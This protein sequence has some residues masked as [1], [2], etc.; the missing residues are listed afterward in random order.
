ME[1]II[2]KE[3]TFRVVSEYYKRLFLEDCLQIRLSILQYAY[4]SVYIYI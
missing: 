4:L 1:K 3:A 2:W